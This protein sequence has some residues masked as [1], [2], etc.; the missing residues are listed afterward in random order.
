[1]KRKSTYAWAKYGFVVKEKDESHDVRREEE[2]DNKISTNRDESTNEDNIDNGSNDINNLSS[3]TKQLQ[4]DISVRKC[5]NTINDDS[6]SS[7]INAF[8]VMKKANLKTNH[9]HLNHFGIDNDHDNHH[10]ETSKQKKKNNSKQHSIMI[11]MTPKEFIEMYRLTNYSYFALLLLDDQQSL[12]PLFTCDIHELMSSIIDKNSILWTITTN[13]KR[14]LWTFPDLMKAPFT[15]DDDASDNNM[16]GSKKDV[17]VVMITNMI[18]FHCHVPVQQ[19]NTQVT[20]KVMTS[21]DTIMETNS[22]GTYLFTPPQSKTHHS[23]HSH[24][25]SSSHHHHD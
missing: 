22:N 6:N 21:T 24:H 1:M 16:H 12:K 13:M 8:D 4:H 7:L 23:D 18:P 25:H 2:D 14:L 10:H 15:N 17:K 20:T 3:K 19:H 11:M 9:H 5:F